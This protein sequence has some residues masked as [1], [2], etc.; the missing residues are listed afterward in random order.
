MKVTFYSICLKLKKTNCM[1]GNI[2]F[3]CNTLTHHTENYNYT[4]LHLYILSCVY[5]YIIIAI[6]IT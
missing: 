6:F 5:A 3:I 2:L 4:L 1:F